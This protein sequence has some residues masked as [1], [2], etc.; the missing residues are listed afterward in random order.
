MMPAQGELGHVQLPEQDGPGG[1]QLFDHGA[2]LRRR[3]G[4]EHL[5]ATGR[6]N[7]FGETQILH[8]YRYPMQRS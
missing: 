4:A 5:G 7:I 6:G 8:G 2:I 3:P 1:R